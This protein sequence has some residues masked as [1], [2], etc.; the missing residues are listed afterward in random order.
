MHDQGESWSL[1]DWIDVVVLRDENGRTVPVTGQIPVD[2]A[3]TKPPHP[4]SL[5]ELLDSTVRVAAG[6][7]NLSVVLD[8]LRVIP[9]PAVFAASPWLVDSRP[10]V[11]RNGIGAL[12]SLSVRYSDS[13]G[14]RISGPETDLEHD[15]Q[16]G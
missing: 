15:D 8:T 10:V 13:A 4:E 5:S 7:G 12:G 1:D 9:V 14:L 11:V 3:D 16:D 2:L 6:E